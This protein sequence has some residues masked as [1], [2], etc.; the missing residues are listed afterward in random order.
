M[1]WVRVHSLG[2]LVGERLDVLFV[3]D[4]LPRAPGFVPSNLSLDNFG[5]R[6]FPY[7]SKGCF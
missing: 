2:F 5:Y 7:F 1:N 3:R 6:G 4:G